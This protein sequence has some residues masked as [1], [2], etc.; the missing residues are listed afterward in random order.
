MKAA[1]WVGKHDIRVEEVPDPKILNRRD[2]ILKVTSTAICGSDLHLYNGYVPT[3]KEYDIMGHEF[4]GEVVEVGPDVHNLKVGDRVIVPFGIACGGCW[5][6]KQGL[7]AACDNSNPNHGQQENGFGH[8]ASALFGYSHL[9]GGYDGGQSEYVRIPFADVSPFKVPHGIPDERLLFLTDVLPT[10]YQAAKQAQ[11]SP[12]DVVAVWGLGPVGQFSVRSALRLGASRVIAIDREEAR[13]ALVR[14]L[15]G[16]EVLDFEDDVDGTNVV[17]ELKN[18]TGNRGPDVCIDAVGF[19]ALGHGA[20]AVV[21][22]AKQLMRMET[23]RPNVLRQA[24]YACRKGGVISIPGV[25]A[26]FSDHFPMGVAFNKGLTFRMGQTHVNRLL[27][28]LM[29]WIEEGFDPGVIISHEVPLERAPE[30]YDIFR[31][32][33]DNCTKV[34]L[35]PG[36]A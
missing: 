8:G 9:F 34:V 4:M 26:G 30:M 17:E 15:P 33:K 25:Y 36:T 18:R 27:P 13:L 29:H 3:M 35:K 31:N 32:K 14:D 12:G 20:G 16:V 23:D 5:F 6:C 19:E 24:I 21:D 10:G 7:T 28:E 22:W 11:I 1:C 2:A